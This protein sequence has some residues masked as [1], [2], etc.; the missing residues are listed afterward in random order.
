MQVHG[1]TR[2][3]II[4]IITSP[5]PRPFAERTTANTIN[6]A[7]GSHCKRKRKNDIRRVGIINTPP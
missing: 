1:K 3:F 7:I 6:N 2:I 4:R 5:S